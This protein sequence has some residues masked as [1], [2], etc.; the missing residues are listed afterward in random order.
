[1]RSRPREPSGAVLS[2]PAR[3]AGPT[4]ATRQLTFLNQAKT[5]SPDTA[6]RLSWLRRHPCFPEQ[7]L[8]V[9]ELDDAVLLRG[10]Q[11]LAVGCDG[12]R[13]NRPGGA[14]EVEPFL[15]RPDVPHL[16]LSPPVPLPSPGDEPPRILDETKRLDRDSVAL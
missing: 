2:G 4:S 16:D 6:T 13:A 3:L 5:W 14:L 7:C 15:P 12:G 8:D 11:R 10:H 9:P 1:S